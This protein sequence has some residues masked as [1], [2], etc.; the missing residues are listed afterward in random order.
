VRDMLQPDVSWL[1]GLVAGMWVVGWGVCKCASLCV[2][3]GVGAH[4]EMYVCVSLGV[5]VVWVHA[6][7]Q[8]KG[9]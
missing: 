3:A 4:R 9:A 2:G 6:E 5:I 7:R 1:S 8:K